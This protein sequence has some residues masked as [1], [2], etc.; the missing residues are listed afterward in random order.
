VVLADGTARG[1]MA[2]MIKGSSRRQ[3]PA[4]DGHS[5]TGLLVVRAVSG[6]GSSG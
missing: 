5:A 1:D 4:E 6:H 3:Y 2:S